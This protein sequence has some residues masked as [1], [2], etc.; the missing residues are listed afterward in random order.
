M[1]TIALIDAAAL[2]AD[3][4]AAPASVLD[5]NLFTIPDGAPA[6]NVRREALAL[7]TTGAAAGVS[8]E[9]WLLD[10]S[11]GPGVAAASRVFRL[12][13]AATAVGQTAVVLVKDA[14]GAV[15]IP[16]GRA[17]LRITAGNGA[18]IKMGVVAV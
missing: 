13:G 11:A 17:Y 15:A 8:A 2:G 3:P 1:R 4:I 7:Y 6:S 14:G 18:G 9:V 12:F 10:E 5:A 16:S